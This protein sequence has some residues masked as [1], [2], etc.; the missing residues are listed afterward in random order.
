[1]ILQDRGTQGGG[2]KVCRGRLRTAW[3]SESHEGK[4]R[5][6]TSGYGISCFDHYVSGE[7]VSTSNGL[8]NYRDEGSR[9]KTTDDRE[10][11]EGLG[12]V[13]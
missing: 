6:R 11:Q 5:H 9:Q 2:F 12:D 1:M 13:E 7:S 3:K 4:R 8:S 10:H